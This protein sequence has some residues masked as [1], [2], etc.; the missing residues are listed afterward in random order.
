MLRELAI[1]GTFRARAVPN[2]E[3][4]NAP[5][6][7]C[8]SSQKGTPYVGVLFEVQEGEDQGCQI[9]AELYLTENTRDRAIESLIHCG[10]DGEDLDDLSTVGS[11]DCQIVVGEEDY[12][13]QVRLKVQWVNAIGASGIVPGPMSAEQRKTFAAS[14]RGQVRA[15]RARLGNGVKATPPPKKPAGPHPNQPGG[16]AEPPPIDDDIGF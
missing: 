8:S 7:L 6:A 4:G 15:T 9:K 12:K 16:A 11:K 13:N 10:W 14:M 3:W 2:P 1:C 5:A